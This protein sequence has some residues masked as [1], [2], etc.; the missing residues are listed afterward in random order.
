MVGV[1]IKARLFLAVCAIAVVAFLQ[2]QARSNEYEDVV[3]EMADSPKTS[4]PDPPA[5][6]IATDEDLSVA[7]SHPLDDH[8]AAGCEL[9]ASTIGSDRSAQPNL[10]RNRHARVAAR[11]AGRR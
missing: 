1:S 4:Q 6:E 9:G 2:G 3:Y 7:P 10:L 5:D 11:R 8:A